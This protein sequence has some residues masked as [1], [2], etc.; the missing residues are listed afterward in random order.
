MSA[1]ATVA[2]S[3]GSGTAAVWRDA[4][5]HCHTHGRN[6]ALDV[7]IGGQLIEPEAADQAGV[8]HD[9][10]GDTGFRQ[11]QLRQTGTIL[12]LTLV[13]SPTGAPVMRVAR[14]VSSWKARTLQPNRCTLPSGPPSSSTR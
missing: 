4:D 11:R 12:A 5:W 1:I 9:A 13:M 2:C 8:T 7:V 6:A 14:P 10:V 3:A